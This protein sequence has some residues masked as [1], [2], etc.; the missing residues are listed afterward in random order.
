MPRLA[1][2]AANVGIAIRKL[3]IAPALEI[4]VGLRDGFAAVSRNPAPRM[5][6]APVRRRTSPRSTKL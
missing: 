1:G 2:L 3:L 5:A 6:L 4:W